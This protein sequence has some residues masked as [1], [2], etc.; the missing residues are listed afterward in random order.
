MGRR[1]KDKSDIMKKY[2]EFLTI[3]EVQ[4]EEAVSNLLE[5]M[6]QYLKEAKELERKG[7]VDVD[8]NRPKRVL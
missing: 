8:D 5:D 7:K 4:H 2:Q 1:K 6:I 3:Y